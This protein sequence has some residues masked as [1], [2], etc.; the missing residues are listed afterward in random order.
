[1]EKEEIEKIEDWFKRSR[2][3][4]EMNRKTIEQHNSEVVKNGYDENYKMK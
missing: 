3:E 1:M 4:V 2:F